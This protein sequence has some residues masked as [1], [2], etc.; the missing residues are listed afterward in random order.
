MID[1]IGDTLKTAKP[2]MSAYHLSSCAQKEKERKRQKKEFQTFG[3]R[4]Y[5]WQFVR[6]LTQK[7]SKAFIVEES[8]NKVDG[9]GMKENVHL[10]VIENKK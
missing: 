10:R 4:V 6:D 7:L 1:A 3:G 8:A 9:S 5:I 2:V